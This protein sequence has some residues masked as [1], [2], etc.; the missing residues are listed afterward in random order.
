MKSKILVLLLVLSVLSVK[1]DGPKQYDLE[2]APNL[3]AKYVKEYHKAYKGK[4][5]TLIHFE[6]FKKS[7][8]E[9]NDLNVQNY[10]NTNFDI[11]QFTDLNDEELSR[12]MG[13]ISPKRNH[14][15]SEYILQPAQSI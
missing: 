11:N 3:F 1:G 9:I 2:D 10:P 5:D 6:Q 14:D 7:L 4:K 8:Q 13:L 12:R 15:R